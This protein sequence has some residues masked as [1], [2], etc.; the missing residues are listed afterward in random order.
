MDGGDS[1]DY[2]VP[3]L[4]FRVNFDVCASWHW[5]SWK[6]KGRVGR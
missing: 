6:L 2:V 5:G 3:R 4:S 1:Y